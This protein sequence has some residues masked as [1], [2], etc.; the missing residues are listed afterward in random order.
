MRAPLTPPS[1]LQIQERS[2][3]LVKPTPPIVPS[4][5]MTFRNKPFVGLLP[6]WV[7]DM[8]AITMLGTSVGAATG[9][10]RHLCSRLR[11]TAA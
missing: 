2:A 9:R 5:L 7:C 3:S 1:P 10:C 4:L 11:S 6:A 8:T